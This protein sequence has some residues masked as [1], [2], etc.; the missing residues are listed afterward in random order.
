MLTFKL[1]FLDIYVF[2]RCT[3][4]DEWRRSR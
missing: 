1:T 3:G 2:G 4:S